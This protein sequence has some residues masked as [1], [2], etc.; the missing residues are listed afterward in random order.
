MK[1]KGWQRK[2]PREYYKELIS[3]AFSSATRCTPPWDNYFFILNPV[4]ILGDAQGPLSSSWRYLSEA[5]NHDYHQSTRPHPHS[6]HSSVSSSSLRSSSSLTHEQH[7]SQF[8]NRQY[9][10]SLFYEPQLQHAIH[11]PPVNTSNTGDTTLEHAI[12]GHDQP[13]AVSISTDHPLFPA[14][15]SAVFASES[16]DPHFH[17][18]QVSSLSSTQ[19]PHFAPHT[20]P[21]GPLTASLSH[22]DIACYHT[23]N[24]VS[25]ANPIPTIASTPTSPSRRLRHGISVAQHPLMRVDTSSTASYSEQRQPSPL[26]S[27]SPQQT[28]TPPSQGSRPGSSRFVIPQ[29]NL[30]G[31]EL[32]EGTPLP[33]ETTPISFAHHRC[34]NEGVHAGSESSTELERPIIISRGRSQHCSSLSPAVDASQWPAAA[35]LHRPESLGCLGSSPSQIA[36]EINTPMGTRWPLG[37]KET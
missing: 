29:L 7:F 21:S 32:F 35:R 27:P 24:H 10:T 13:R 16:S 19:S 22:S 23:G 34:Q 2:T 5:P 25:M 33:T 31:R 20:F 9:P 30:S 3:S 26:H 8:D 17:S 36:I 1:A 12:G 14:V 6:V 15:Q 11:S 18:I 4:Y 28:H 37:G